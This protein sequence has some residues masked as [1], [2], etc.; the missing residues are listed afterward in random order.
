MARKKKETATKSQGLGDTVEKIT[1]AT[2][3]KKV[4]ELFTNGKDC[5]CDERK[6]KLNALFPYH[7]QPDCM[8]EEEHKLWG[9][10][11]AKM[12]PDTISNEER[13]VIAKIHARL[14]SHKV[15]KPCSCNKSIWKQWLND[16]DKVF[17][18]YAQD[19]RK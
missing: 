4:V 1:K 17:E 3:I 5:G 7:I 14:F 11:K 10:T 18:T 6:E 9:E 2:G 16:L 15:K 12:Q 19:N 8:S 13:E